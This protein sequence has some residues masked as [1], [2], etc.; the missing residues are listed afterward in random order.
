MVSGL[1]SRSNPQTI[2]LRSNSGPAS[3]LPAS[4]R[5]SPPTCMTRPVQTVRLAGDDR[6]FHLRGASLVRLATRTRQGS[7]HI[8][9]KSALRRCEKRRS[10]LE[11]GWTEKGRAAGGVIAPE[12]ATPSL[13]A[14]QDSNL[15]QDGAVYERR[16]W[17]NRSEDSLHHL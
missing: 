4:A 10:P 17:R 5:Y 11:S 3:P 1:S 6:G 7:R 15:P 16:G 2:R 12:Q 8:Q 13:A 9:Q 14:L